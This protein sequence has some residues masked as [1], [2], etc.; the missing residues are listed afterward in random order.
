MRYFV[1]AE[2]GNK[3]GP[4]DVGTLNRWIE[5]GRVL[6]AMMLEE[7]GT[8]HRVAAASIGG[9]EFYAIETEVS[10][11]DSGSVAVMT[12]EQPAT[13]NLNVDLFL[14]WSMVVVT[15]GLSAVRMAGGYLA[16][17]TTLLGI[18]AS[19]KAKERGHA[20]AGPAIVINLLAFV[21]WLAARLY[22]SM[23]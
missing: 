11:T 10:S 5:E 1:F 15:L 6:P 9:L 7:E 13:E 21:V 4:A 3:Y 12:F 18:M 23:R 16:I 2:D 14:A 20:A 22:M 17:F 8:H 19:I